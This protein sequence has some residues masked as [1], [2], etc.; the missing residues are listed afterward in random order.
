MFPEYGGAVQAKYVHRP[1]AIPMLAVPRKKNGTVR[2][3]IE[4]AFRRIIGI[5]SIATYLIVSG[6]TT[7]AGL[8]EP[9]VKIANVWHA[10]LPHDGRA[11]DLVSWWSTFFD[12]SLTALIATAQAQNP[13][14]ESAAAKIEMA[15]ATLAS[16][17]AALF[18]GLGGSGSLTRSGTGG[19]K[20]NKVAATTTTSG[21]LDA[22]WEIDLFG[23]TRQKSE[24]A[25]L[26]LHEQV[27][28]WHNARVSLAA[29]VA[30]HYVQYR[31]CRQLERA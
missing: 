22:S 3:T 26:R 24:A 2:T 18:P 15:R 4:A 14:I 19:D 12:P 10:T 27:A 7:P 23:K 17:Q 30:D 29:E 25:R 9:D 20:T 11:S 31:A 16:A 8:W 28:D 21:G 1:M 13:N 5:G 6:C